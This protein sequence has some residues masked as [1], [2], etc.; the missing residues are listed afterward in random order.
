MGLLCEKNKVNESIESIEL[1][2]VSISDIPQIKEILY[3]SVLSLDLTFM[4]IIFKKF[5]RD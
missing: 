1:N 5:F 2:S 4:L 3:Y